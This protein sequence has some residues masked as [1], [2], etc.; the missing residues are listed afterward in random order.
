MTVTVIGCGCTQ[1][2]RSKTKE[3]KKK[4]DFE[5]T[6]VR[7]DVALADQGAVP[8]KDDIEDKVNFE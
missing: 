2:Y 1:L 4:L 6:E 8:E 3:V 5:M 7:D